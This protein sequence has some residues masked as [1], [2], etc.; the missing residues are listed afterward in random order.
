[1]SALSDEQLVSELTRI[2]GW[3]S[4]P[5]EAYVRDLI[6]QVKGNRPVASADGA[7]EQAPVP[8]KKTAAPRKRAAKKT[9]ATS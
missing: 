2:A 6:E 7:S 8:A 5:R 4:G 3:V 1:M 9:A